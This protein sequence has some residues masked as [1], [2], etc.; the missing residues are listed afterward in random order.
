MMKL[1]C[2]KAVWYIGALVVVIACVMACTFAWVRTWPRQRSDGWYCLVSTELTDR[3]QITIIA[4]GDIE[5]WNRVISWEWI[6]D[7]KRSDSGYLGV[8]ESKIP[9]RRL[10]PMLI[11]LTNHTWGIYDSRTG[12]LWGVFRIE[13]DRPRLMRRS[14]VESEGLLKEVAASLGRSEIQ[15]IPQ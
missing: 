11:T 9:L 12:C 6:R 10:A 1:R 7:G 14:E 8:V 13:A 2:H 15:W 4:D 5:T 3:S